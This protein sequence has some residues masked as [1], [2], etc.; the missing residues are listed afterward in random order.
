MR[1]PRLIV[2]AACSAALVVPMAGAVAQ[3]A[4]AVPDGLQL[5]A[6]HHSLLATHEWYVQT[7]AGH[8]VLGS[9]YARHIDNRTGRVTVDDGRVAVTG[10]GAAAAPAVRPDQAAASASGQPLSSQLAVL[11][12]AQAKLVYAVVSN[13]DSGALRTIVD[14]G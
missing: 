2:T 10:L 7:F 4:P 1:L 9:H 5:I 11:P 12:G 13:T 3:A 14:A 6:T 8:K